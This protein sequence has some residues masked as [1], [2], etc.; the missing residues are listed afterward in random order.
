L[1][2]TC[3]EKIGEFRNDLSRKEFDIS[4]MCQECQDSAFAP[5]DDDELDAELE[6][7]GQPSEYQEWHDYMGGDDWDQGQF[8][9][10]GDF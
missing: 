10:Y 2:P 8:E 7:D 3:G 5:D 4:F 6:G 9:N 1:C